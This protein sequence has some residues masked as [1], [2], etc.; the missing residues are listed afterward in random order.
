MAAG[1]W[2]SRVLV[3]GMTG[4]LSIPVGSDPVWSQSLP[5]IPATVATDDEEQL[6]PMPPLL[7]DTPESPSETEPDSA[8]RELDLSP[9]ILENSPVLRRWLEEIPDISQDIRHDP[10]FRTRLRLGY[11]QF[12]STDQAAGWLVGV[13]DVFVGQT[14]LTVSG[15]YQASFN[16]DRESFGADLRYYIL[17]L[18]GYINVAPVVGYRNLKTGDYEM[19]GVNI[20][21]RVFLVLSRT[22]AADIS[23]TQSFVSP[24]SSD[25]VGIATLSVGYA[26]TENLRLSA[27]IQKQNSREEK[28]SRVGI[29][30][31]WIP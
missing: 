14:G 17:P 31:E 4:L 9:E 5:S 2:Q 16:G 11:A 26:V 27:D 12:P 13:E 25:E 19:D 7:A 23:L 10:S 21:V 29:V 8:A 18:G 1:Q 20:G 22:G 6:A 3:L 24:G 15:E 28:D 30:L